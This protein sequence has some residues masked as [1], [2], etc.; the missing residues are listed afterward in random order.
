MAL[1]YWRDACKTN[2][3]HI[4]EEHRYLFKVLDEL[5]QQILGEAGVSAL[6]TTLDH[7]FN[8]AIKHC[9]TEEILMES[10]GYPDYRL[11]A[12]QHE[13]LLSKILNLQL[14]ITTQAAQPSIDLA[15]DLANWLSHHTWEYDLK[16]VQFVLLQQRHS[17]WRSQ[18]R[19]SM[20]IRHGKL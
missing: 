16:L 13:A 5:Y 19:E 18:A 4:D 6:E 7:L 11:H 12:D 8:V 20:P 10:S 2:H 3:P 14:Q 1:A 9:E 17:C 15:H